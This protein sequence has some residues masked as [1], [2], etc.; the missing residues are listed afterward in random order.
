MNPRS[1]GPEQPIHALQDKG[2]LTPLLP[3]IIC[4]HEICS[5]GRRLPAQSSF[6]A[7]NRALGIMVLVSASPKLWLLGVPRC[8]SGC[9]HDR[10]GP[11]VAC[12]P[13]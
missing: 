11:G 4:A 2:C 3:A 9:I 8:R 13:G 1:Q 12:G 10:R 7:Q 6:A 5:T